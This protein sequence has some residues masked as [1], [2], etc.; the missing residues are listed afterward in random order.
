MLTLL[1]L[2]IHGNGNSDVK[3][4]NID[5]RDFEVAAVSLNKVDGLIIEDC[6]VRG[7]RQDVP[8]MATYSAARFISP[9]GKMLKDLDYEMVLRGE[10]VKATD[11]YDALISSINN[12]YEDVVIDGLGSID[13]IEH[14]EEYKL[15]HNPLR[16]I[17]GPW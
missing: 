6:F 13:P 8:V 3:I 5:F 16:V 14:P 10:I 11:A 7:N 1:T 2:G 17:D 4:V 15:F 9:Y 12:V